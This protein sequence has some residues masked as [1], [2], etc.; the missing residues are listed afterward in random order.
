M[1]M[2]TYLT[3]TAQTTDN[4][5]YEETVSYINPTVSNAVCDGFAEELFKLSQDTYVDAVRVNKES[6][7]GASE[8]GEG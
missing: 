3:L 1:A 7:K 5:L 6:V 2:R 8:G 4:K